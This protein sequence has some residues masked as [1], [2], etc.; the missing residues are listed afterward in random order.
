MQGATR[1]FAQGDIQDCTL[2][3]YRACNRAGK[4]KVMLCM[5]YC[6]LSKFNRLKIQST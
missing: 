3:E 6:I 5:K 2:N 4:A 1:R